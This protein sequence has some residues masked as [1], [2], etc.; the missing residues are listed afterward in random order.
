METNPSLAAEHRFFAPSCLKKAAISLCFYS[1]LF[2]KTQFCSLQYLSATVK[3]WD[4]MSSL[5][6]LSLVSILL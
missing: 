1:I 5:E 3:S 2:K 4:P 6:Y